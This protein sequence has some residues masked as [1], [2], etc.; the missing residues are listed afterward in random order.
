MSRTDVPRVSSARGFTLVELV[1]TIAI[2][3]MVV[4]GALLLLEQLASEARRVTGA[5]VAA[6][7]EANG[8]RLLRQLVGQVEL[9]ANDSAWFGGNEHQAR[10][11]TWCYVPQGWQERCAVMLAIDT[12]GRG[13]A[14][15][16][17]MRN[18]PALVLWSH[19][20]AVEFRYLENAADGGSWLSRWEWGM[21]VP[22]AIGIVT[23]RGT[24]VDTTIVRVGAGG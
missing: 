18:R 9:G 8:R 19:V 10:F 24:L 16:G 6:D 14:I 17:Q 22:L 3:G 15:M 4:L 20:D 7:R 11:T 21:T 2:S 1:V 12:S 5:T 13:R 23:R